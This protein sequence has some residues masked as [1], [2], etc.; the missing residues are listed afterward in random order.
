[1]QEPKTGGHIV[2][3]VKMRES[4]SLAWFQLDFSTLTQF[5]TPCLGNVATQ[6]GWVLP[7]QLT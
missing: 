5:R 4:H 7:Y 6:S 3:T 1:M 2:A